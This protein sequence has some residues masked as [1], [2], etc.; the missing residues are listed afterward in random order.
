MLPVGAAKHR[1]GAEQ[2]KRVV[3]RPRIVDRDVPQ[4]VLADLLR[5]IDVDTQEVG[6]RLRL[7]TA[8]IAQTDENNSRSTWAASTSCRSVW[9]Q[10]NEGASRQTQKNSTRFRDINVPRF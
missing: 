6:Y 8:E 3:R 7:A 9:N 4:H 1:A 10:P 5:E 2:G